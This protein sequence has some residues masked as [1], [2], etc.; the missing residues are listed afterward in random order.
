ML[1]AQM[2]RELA[3]LA[4]RIGVDVRYEV[5]DRHVLEGRGGLCWLRGKPVVVMDSGMPVLD[6]VGVLATA[7]A[8]F[9]LEPIYIPPL[10]RR[11]LESRSPRVRR[12]RVGL[13]GT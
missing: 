6:K 10:L 2:L 4:A 5:F 7:L 11:R 13:G 8:R 12:L 9:D 1:P 3:E